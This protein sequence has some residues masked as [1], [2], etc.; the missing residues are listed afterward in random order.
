M[1]LTQTRQNLPKVKGCY[2]HLPF[3]QTL[4]SLSLNFKNHFVCDVMPEGILQIMNKN[5]V[6]V[7]GTKNV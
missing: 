4:H 1:S 6:H 3:E 7:S 5:V 2:N